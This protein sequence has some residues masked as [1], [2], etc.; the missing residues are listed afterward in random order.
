MSSR[1]WT[2]SAAQLPGPLSSLPVSHSPRP[3]FPPSPLSLSLSLN[4]ALVGTT[5]DNVGGKPVKSL[6]YSAYD[7]LALRTMLA[8]ASRIR[9]SHRLQAIAIVH[10]LG[11][12]PIGEESILIAV[13][14][15]HRKAAWLAGQEA[16]DECK[17]KLEVWKRETLDGD[18]AV[19]KAN[20]DDCANDHPPS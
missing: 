13:S 10:R 7:S 11:T 2:R 5:R 4:P 18:E 8:I 3:S 15:P 1:P 9:A 17:A 16:L 20:R 6:A 12:V 14:A 19:W